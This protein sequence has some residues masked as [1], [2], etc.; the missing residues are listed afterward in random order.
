M[1]EKAKTPP[2]R[3]LVETLMITLDEFQKIEAEFPKQI[4]ANRERREGKPVKLGTRQKNFLASAEKDAAEA[5][6][7]LENSFRSNSDEQDLIKSALSNEKFDFQTWAWLYES[8]HADDKPMA[9]RIR[10]LQ[11]KLIDEMENNL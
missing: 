3:T 9:N 2:F 6:S 7:Y 10:G 5:Y 11:K 4:A 1:L 8:V